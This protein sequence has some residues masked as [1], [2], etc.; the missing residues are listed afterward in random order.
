M[1]IIVKE[2]ATP[3]TPG[4]DYSVLYPKTDGKWYFKDDGGTEF[5]L[6]GRPATETAVATT[7][8]T[9]HDITTVPSWA[10]KITMALSRVSTNS[11]ARLLVQLGT[12]A[13]LVTSGY[14]SN[15]VRITN[16]NAS[17]GAGST[18]G[19]IIDNVVNTDDIIIIM[20]LMLVNAATNTWTAGHSGC[21]TAHSI[22]G[23]G[24]VS[25]PGVLDRFRLTTV[26]G[27]PTFDAG[28]W[29]VLYE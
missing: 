2:Q 20:T 9:S 21:K 29:N 19:L 16:S 11:T 8:G 14:V 26:T 24:D 5:P 22:V 23:G 17:N 15:S 12:S 13:G 28:L 27:T 7:S 25:L 6:D 18:E 4:T 1:S 10:K 3:N